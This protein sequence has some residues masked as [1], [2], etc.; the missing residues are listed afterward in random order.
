MPDGSVCGKPLARNHVMCTGHRDYQM[1]KPSGMAQLDWEKEKKKRELERE[2]ERSA[3]R[4][5]NREALNRKI[6]AKKMRRT[7][8]HAQTASASPSIQQLFAIPAPPPQRQ[9]QQQQPPQQQHQPSQQTNQPSQPSQQT[10]QQLSQLIQQL[11]LQPTQ[12]PNQQPSQQPNQQPSQQA[13]LQEQLTQVQQTAKA[14]AI[15]GCSTCQLPLLGADHTMDCKKCGAAFHDYAECIR[16]H[17]CPA[18][19]AMDEDD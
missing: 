16:E 17:E 15:T 1:R 13:S 8:R 19:D 5:R 18:A 12:Q 2:K 3:K 9:Q 14:L 10:S 4:A 7:V 6:A 11:N